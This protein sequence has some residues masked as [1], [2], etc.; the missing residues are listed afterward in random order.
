MA[1][2]AAATTIGR[3]PGREIALAASELSV[4]S[5]KLV[6]DA[7]KSSVVGWAVVDSRVDS[8]IDSGVVSEVESAVESGVTS[9]SDSEV[10]SVV[11]SGVAPE[12]VDVGVDCTVP[13]GK[14]TDA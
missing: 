5:A 13:V 12:V 3:A 8:E 4:G 2:A 9:E 11:G 7:S 14:A 1:A 6:E 10:V